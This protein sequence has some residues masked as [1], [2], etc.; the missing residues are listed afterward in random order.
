M[1]I[2]IADVLFHVPADLPVID[3]ANIEPRPAGLRR[4]SRRTSAPAAR[5]CSKSRTT[6]RP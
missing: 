6:R 1:D 3:R 5:T 2:N 4:G